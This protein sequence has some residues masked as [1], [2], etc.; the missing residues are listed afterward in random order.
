MKSLVERFKE[1]PEGLK[2]G[3]MLEVVFQLSGFGKGDE[4]TV[5]PLIKKF[6]GVRG[7]FGASFEQLI[8]LGR[9]GEKPACLIVAIRNLASGILREKIVGRDAIRCKKDVLAYLKFSLSAERVE[10]FVAI[11][12]N[13]KN[14]VLAVETLHEGAVSRGAVYP[15]KA[16]ERAFL[17]NARSVVFAHNHPSGDFTPSMEDVRLIRELDG[18]A[19]AVNLIVHDHIIIGANRHFSARENGWIIGAPFQPSAGE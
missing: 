12:M 19:L 10:K 18:A 15:R 5:E 13:S 1:N 2:S 9:L 3:E 7:V 8:E 4:K 16:I 17:H 6:G 14:E 11:Y